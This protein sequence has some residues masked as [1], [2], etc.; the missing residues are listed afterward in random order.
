MN[1]DATETDGIEACST[2]FD[3]FFHGMTFGRKQGKEPCFTRSII[4]ILDTNQKGRR[5][6]GE[7]SC[8]PDQSDGDQ[9]TKVTT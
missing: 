3:R 2:S 8:D 6:E 9:K 7:V 5:G 1:D 4:L